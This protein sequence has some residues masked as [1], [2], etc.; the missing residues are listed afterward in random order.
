MIKVLRSDQLT[1][2]ARRGRGFTILELAIVAAVSAVIFLVLLRWMTSLGQVAGSVADKQI[3]TR[4]ADFA[5]QM[6]DADMRA[7]A[8][9][10]LDDASPVRLVSDRV[11]ELYVND[12]R[13]DGTFGLRL[14]RWHAADGELTRTVWDVN[15]SSGA[16]SCNPLP[17]ATA[18][19]I[20]IATSVY[21]PT[22]E[23][24]GRSVVPIFTAYVNGVPDTTACP[25]GSGCAAES[26]RF[27]GVFLTP[28]S[29]TSDSQ[30]WVSGAS[31]TRVD[32]VF[33]VA[34]TQRAGM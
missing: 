11:L 27:D 17:G 2:R 19:A 33:E 29:S 1:G 30:Q 21:T 31:P 12:Q 34:T 9:C 15:P 22:P 8:L 24:T 5:V 13:S 18:S 14:V 25:S 28:G 32:R 26:V 7:A 20:V 6:L 23:S 10:N 4:N 16:Q 3:S